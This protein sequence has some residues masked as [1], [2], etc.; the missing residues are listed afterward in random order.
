MNK[1]TEISA[2][3]E[4]IM[5]LLKEVAG[6]MDDTASNSPPKLRNEDEVPDASTACDATTEQ[7]RAYSPQYRYNYPLP[8]RASKDGNR[9]LKYLEMNDA[10]TKENV[11]DIIMYY[12]AAT[13]PEYLA[14]C[15]EGELDPKELPTLVID[16]LVEAIDETLNDYREFKKLSKK[17][18]KEL[19]DKDVLDALRI[20][21]SIF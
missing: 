7:K 14:D 9:L 1:N 20:M 13:R 19:L 12:L 4:T 16:T 5:S 3:L 11:I 8:I 18:Q 2:D 10:P 21:Q 17:E 15:R 6:K